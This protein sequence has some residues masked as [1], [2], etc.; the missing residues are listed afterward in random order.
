MF[1]EFMVNVSIVQQIQI[2]YVHIFQNVIHE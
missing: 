2:Q 1:V